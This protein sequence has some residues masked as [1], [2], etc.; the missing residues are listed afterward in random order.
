MKLDDPFAENKR[1]SVNQDRISFILH[2]RIL[3]M[4]IYF[5]FHD[6]RF[7]HPIKIIKKK[8]L[9]SSLAWKLENFDFFESFLEIQAH[10]WIFL[11]KDIVQHFSTTK[12]SFSLF[13]YVLFWVS[14][15]FTIR[16]FYWQIIHSLSVF[17][18]FFVVYK[19]TRILFEIFLSF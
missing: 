3:N 18:Q 10:F 11:K 2:D 8:T 6:R 4:I 19:I 14:I 16:L 12:C 15:F 1:S 9:T 5:T 13:E 17:G 7:Y